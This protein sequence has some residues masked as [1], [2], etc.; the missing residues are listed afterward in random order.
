M[1]VAFFASPQKPILAILAYSFS[2]N[3][4]L[5]MWRQA[6]KSSRTAVWHITFLKEQILLISPSFLCFFSS[7]VSYR[8]NP[9]P[10]TNEK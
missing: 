5:I 3:R 8:L 1:V 2:I 7:L 10:H 4:P 9:T 6:D